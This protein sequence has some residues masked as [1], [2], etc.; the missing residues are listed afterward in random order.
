VTKIA[1]YFRSIVHNESA[2]RASDPGKD[3]QLRRNFK[4]QRHNNEEKE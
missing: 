4:Q 2:G 1:K 3:T